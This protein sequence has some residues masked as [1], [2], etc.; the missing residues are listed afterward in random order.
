[1]Y[2]FSSVIDKLYFD[3]DG[4][5]KGFSQALPFAQYFF[6][7]LKKKG[8]NVVPVASG[9]KGFNLYVILRQQAIDNAKELL[10][11]VQYSLIVECFGDVTPVTI[12]DDLGQEHPSL[13][14]KEGLIYFDPKVLGDVRRFSRIPNTLRPPENLTYCTYLNPDEFPS[15]T[16]SDVAKNMKQQ[17]TFD[18]DLRTNIKITQVQ[19]IERLEERVGKTL[20]ENMTNNLKINNN[21]KPNTFLKHVLRPCLYRHIITTAPRH[22]VRVATTADL[23]NGGISEET[24][25]SVYS[26][27][28]WSDF[29]P[30]I[31]SVQITSCKHLKSYSCSK[32]RQLGIPEVCCVG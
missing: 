16:S 5:E 32:L 18:F 25:F 23:L 7:F 10:T 14:N 28:A 9:K 27:L 19:I 3:L 1:M 8:L 22:D 31:T 6:E 11:Q 21:G 29:D 30:G 12:L 17:H 15:M 26:K 24:I 2:P 13:Q 20:R 4:I